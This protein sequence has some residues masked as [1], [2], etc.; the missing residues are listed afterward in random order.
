MQSN[1]SLSANERI[2]FTWR[3]DDFDFRIGASTNYQRTY[4]DQSVTSSTFRN[5]A[6]SSFTWNWELPGITFDTDVNYM[7]YNGFETN[8]GNTLL[9]NMEIEKLLFKNQASLSLRGYDLLGQTKNFSVSTNGTNYTESF[10]NSLGRYVI[11][12]FTWR[13]NSFGGQRGRGG[14]GGGRGMG[15]G[16]MGGGMPPMF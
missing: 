9:W 6:T 1:T 3:A 2:T 5:A 16:M 4:V 10:T 8:P 12:A 11:V 7:W 14:M 15:G 13:F